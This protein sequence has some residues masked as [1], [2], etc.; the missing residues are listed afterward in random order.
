[1]GIIG[2][3]RLGVVP[4]DVF[5]HREQKMCAW[6]C[7]STARDPAPGRRKG[8][9]AGKIIVYG[10]MIKFSHS[11]FALPFALAAVA[12]ASRTHP[13][14]FTQL[15]WILTAMVGARSAAMGF[16]RIVDARFDRDT[17]RTAAREIPSGRLSMRAALVFVA[18]SSGLF[19]LA[20]AML[21][22]LCLIL[23]LPVLAV[24][25]M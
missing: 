11:I 17:P 8:G 3:R 4:C 12:L 5:N 24:L 19:L 1:M 21:S 14:T 23:A 15:C 7:H 16:N 2:M 22:R 20:A 13:V 10:R 6:K 25:F 9:L 18:V